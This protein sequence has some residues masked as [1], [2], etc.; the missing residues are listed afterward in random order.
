MRALVCGFLLAYSAIG[1]AGY[2]ADDI[3]H[4]AVKLEKEFI[5]LFDR[6]HHERHAIKVT[7]G[8]LLPS[9]VYLKYD[10]QFHGWVYIK[11]EKDAKFPEPTEEL[12]PDS[13]A[14]GSVIG[15]QY[16]LQRFILNDQGIWVPTTKTEQYKLYVKTNPPK[17]QTLTYAKPKLAPPSRPPR[18]KPNR[19]KP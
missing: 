4:G 7:D 5:Y 14:P 3:T 15:A 19:P 1:W 10:E 6:A 12:R 2:S 16:A 11:T 18:T 9:R 17:L 8:I 13:V